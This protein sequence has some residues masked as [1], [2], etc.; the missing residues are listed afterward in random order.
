MNYCTLVQGNNEI[1]AKAKN[2]ANNIENRRYI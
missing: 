2:R 1:A